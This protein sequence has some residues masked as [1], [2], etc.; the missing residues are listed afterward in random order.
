M[1]RVD[2]ILFATEMGKCDRWLRCHVCVRDN[3]FYSLLII[4]HFKKEGRGKKE[5]GRRKREEGTKGT[6]QG[7]RGK[8]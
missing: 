6:K 5:E 4:A 2:A 7:G 3:I 1:F 8:K